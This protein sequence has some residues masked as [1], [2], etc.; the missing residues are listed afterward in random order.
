MEPRRT[1]EIALISSAY[2]STA[3]HADPNE[4]DAGRM[5]AAC[6]R[7]ESQVAE[8]QRQLSQVFTSRAPHAADTQARNKPPPWEDELDAEEERAR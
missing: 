1:E 2:A 3:A 8:L 6:K 7:L 5:P 4:I